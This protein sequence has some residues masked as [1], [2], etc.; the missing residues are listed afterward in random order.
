[1]TNARLG[2][3]AGGMIFALGVQALFALLLLYSLPRLGTQPP[4]RE[5]ILLLPRRAVIP[6]PIIIDAR[7]KPR[8]QAAAVPAAPP[9]DNAITLPPVLPA[10]P[11][12]ILQGIGRSLFGCAP[13]DVGTAEARARC[14]PM[15]VARPP[16]DADLMS[17]PPS[18]IKDEAHWAN[19]WSREHAPLQLPCLGGLD[20]A[21]LVETIASGHGAD[22]LDPRLWPHDQVQR[23]S[24]PDFARIEQA[25]DEWHRLHGTP[26]PSGENVSAAAAGKSCPGC[27]DAPAGNRGP[28]PP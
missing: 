25:Y 15:V 28:A 3:Q 18:H 19:E 4:A 8:P 5:T 12:A 23:L 20:V 21:C 2:K 11:S 9:R 27:P 13:E 7:Q 24:A 14:G 10:A 6:P 26:K 1:M 17:P 22:M 16:P